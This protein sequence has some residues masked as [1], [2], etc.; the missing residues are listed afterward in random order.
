MKYFLAQD[1]GRFPGTTPSG[2]NIYVPV[3]CTG[4]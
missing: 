1:I 3:L 2:D 4:T